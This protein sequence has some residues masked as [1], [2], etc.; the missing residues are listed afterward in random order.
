MKNFVTKR[1]KDLEST[2]QTNCHDGSEDDLTHCFKEHGSVPEG[3]TILRDARADIQEREF[4]AAEELDIEEDE[5]N[6]Y[7]SDR[8]LF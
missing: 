2:N 6:G 8:S 5:E 1:S 3:R 4:T 7:A